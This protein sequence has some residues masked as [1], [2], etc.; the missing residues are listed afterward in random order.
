MCIYIYIYI[1]D[2]YMYIYIYIYIYTYEKHPMSAMLR[3]IAQGAIL[4]C[5]VYPK[6]GLSVSI[7]A[8]YRYNIHIIQI[9]I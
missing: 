6:T 8:A 2:T 5:H 3:W 9:Y 4:T 1:Y 7:S